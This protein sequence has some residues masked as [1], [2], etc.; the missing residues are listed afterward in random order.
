MREQVLLFWIGLA[1]AGISAAHGQAAGIRRLGGGEI[2]LDFRPA[3]TSIPNAAVSRQFYLESSRDMVSWDQVDDIDLD[4]PYA[5]QGGLRVP[6]ALTGG[7]QQFFRFRT[8]QTVSYTTDNAA[9]Y[10][11]FEG[12]FTTALFDR[13]FDKPADLLKAYP[14]R[15]YLGDLPWDV[16]TAEFWNLFD[17]DPAVNNVGRDPF[18]DGWR[19]VDYR[20]NADER[21]ILDKNGFVVSERLGTY[22]FGDAFY[23]LWTDDL[24]VY[25]STDA[26]LQAWHFSFQKCLEE[27]DEIVMAYELESILSGM[28][29]GLGLQRPLHDSGDAFLP[30][31]S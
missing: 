14:A 18:K 7:E 5:F 1:C 11:G 25:I 10:L 17:T 27:T 24:P 3:P 31:Y 26:L 15:E 22:S 30:I 20:L 23:D 8:D 19:V 9:E 29:A 16:S 21:A 2:W 12:T 28:R 6:A 4:N 13:Y